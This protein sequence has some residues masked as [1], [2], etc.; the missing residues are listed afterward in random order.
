MSKQITIAIDGAAATGKS[1]VA[2]RLS[3]ELNYLY[4]DTG[5]M[6]RAATWAALDQ[7]IDIADES[8]VS[9]RTERMSLRITPPT[10]DDGRQ[11]TVLVG[12]QDITWAIR[13]A[14]VEQYVSR[15]SS[16]PRVRTALT[17]Q[18]RVMAQQGAIIMAGRDIGTV[19]LPQ[20]ELKI[21]MLASAERRAERRYD[22]LIAKGE[23]ANYEEVLTAIRERDRQD[24]EKPISPLVPAEDAVLVDTDQLNIEQVMAELHRLVE[25]RVAM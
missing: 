23:T 25:Q 10:Q 15:V 18:Q 3:Q 12:E 8:A 13:S 16:Y 22:E 2:E 9:E 14:E 7:Q 20:A 17:E 11:C 24:T 5:V 6:Y 1:T 21:F 4:L 19:V